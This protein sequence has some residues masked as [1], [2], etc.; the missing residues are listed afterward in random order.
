MARSHEELEAARLLHEK[1]FYFKSVSS[2]YY[3]IYAR[4][5]LKKTVASQSRHGCRVYVASVT[6]REISSER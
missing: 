6:G 3:A 4:R 5:G 1:G 2:S